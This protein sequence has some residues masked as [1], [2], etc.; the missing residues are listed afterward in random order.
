MNKL[1]AVE[2]VAVVPTVVHAIAALG[3]WNTH[4]VV[5]ATELPHRRTHKFN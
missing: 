3:D 4:P 2:L 1:T 5:V